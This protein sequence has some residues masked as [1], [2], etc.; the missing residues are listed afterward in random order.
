MAKIENGEKLKAHSQRVRRLT[1]H[2]RKHVNDFWD[3][4]QNLEAHV[5]EFHAVPEF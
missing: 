3:S 5:L 4:E 1:D 2:E